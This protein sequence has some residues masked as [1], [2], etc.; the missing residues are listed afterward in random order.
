MN[1]SVTVARATSVMSSLCLEIRLSSRSKGPSKLS[2]RTANA[3]VASV[4]DAQPG[5]PARRERSEWRGGVV[6]SSLLG[7]PPD[8]DALLAV[9][10]EVGQ[11]EREGLADQAAPVDGQPVVAA[12]PE[13]RLL[14]VRGARRR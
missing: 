5:P 13:P 11:H 2:S 3:G 6:M 7:Q 1:S 8:Q 12:Q 14:E 10:L 4:L 9:R